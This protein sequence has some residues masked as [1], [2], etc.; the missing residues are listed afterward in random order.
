MKIL[1]VSNLYPP[2][3]LGGYELSCSQAADALA[4]LCHEVV[5]LTSQPGI[6]PPSDPQASGPRVERSLALAPVFDSEQVLSHQLVMLQALEARSQ[7]IDGHNTGVLIQAIERF[8]PDVVYL[9]NLIGIGGLGLLM[10]L[11]V[12]DVPWVWHLCDRVPF[13]LCSERGYLVPPLAEAF[14]HLVDGRWITLSDQLRAEIGMLGVPLTGKITKLPLWVD[15]EGIPVRLPRPDR[16]ALRLAFAGQVAVHKGADLA[17][18]AV[19]ELHRQGVD[20]SLDLWG[21]V[22]DLGLPGRAAAAGLA[23]RVVFHG[24]TDHA[25]VIEGIAACDLLLFPTW[26]REPFGVVPAEAA[27][28]GTPPILSES[29]VAEW[30]VDGVH[31]IHVPR[32]VEGLVDAVLRVERGEIDLMELARSGAARVRSDLLVES[33]IPS[34]ERELQDAARPYRPSSSRAR[35]AYGLATVAD[36][37][38]GDLVERR[39]P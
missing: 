3:V 26:P 16:P 30:L 18:E 8:R 9:W 23:D 12:M 11:R 10:A 27:A 37:L 20:V 29:G 35:R 15:T 4:R 17:V 14:G 13:Q 24:P 38:V 2:S 1:V 25:G 19:I 6:A 34:I 36:R 28:V 21:E 31:A 7:W 32:S 33:I 39:W 22:L 5:V